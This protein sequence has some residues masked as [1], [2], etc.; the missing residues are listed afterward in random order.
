MLRKYR[1]PCGGRLS[2]T[3]SAALRLQHGPDGVKLYIMTTTAVSSLLVCVKMYKQQTTH[4]K[5]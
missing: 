4:F 2:S 3:K 1:G 5:R